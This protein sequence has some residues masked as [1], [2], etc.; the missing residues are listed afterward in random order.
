MPREEAETSLV[1]TVNR[2]LDA[3]T[4]F[5]QLNPWKAARICGS[6]CHLLL[7]VV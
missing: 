6:S 3:K 2:G 4:P 1:G 5:D 7:W